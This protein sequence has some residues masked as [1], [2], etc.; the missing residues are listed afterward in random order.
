MAKRHWRK[1]QS[2]DKFFRRAQ[3]EGYRARS[4]YKLEGINQKFRIL[5]K[6]D[7]VLDIGAAPGSWSQKAS[8]IVGE[9]GHVIAVDIQP[10]QPIQGVTVIQGDIRDPEVSARIKEASG[11]EAFNAVISDIAPNTTGIAIT[12]HARSIE[13]SLFALSIALRTVRKGGNF[14]TKVFTGEDFDDLLALTKRYFRLATAF[15]PEAT[16]KESK[17][18][19]IVAKNLQARAVLDPNL[20]P[21]ALLDVEPEEA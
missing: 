20:G 16:R 2:K 12:D 3:E 11:G 9:Q 13:L 10:I 5:R 8:E 4:A 14:V 17:E 15:D 1:Q 18:T 19:F 7:R 6:G 21:A